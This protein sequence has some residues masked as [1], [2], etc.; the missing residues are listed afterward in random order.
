MI[1]AI[2]E[3]ELARLEE[4]A[5]SADLIPINE[6]ELVCLYID[7]I[8]EHRQSYIAA[9]CNAVPA[10]VAEVRRLREALNK[11][12]RAWQ[13]AEC[14][15]DDLEMENAYLREKVERFEW[16]WEVEAFVDDR[17]FS[18]R[19]DAVKELQG[20]WNAAREAVHA[21]RE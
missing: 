4:L 11:E 19:E 6:D 15:G 16:A 8:D 18:M 7:G 20:T 14:R 12:H 10:M 2:D 13:C 21:D 5:I 17:I 3:T 1:S 9:A